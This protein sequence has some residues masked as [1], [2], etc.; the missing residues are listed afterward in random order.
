MET[1]TVT[2]NDFV[3]APPPPPPVDPTAPPR[4]GTGP[5]AT[6]AGPTEPVAPIP[7]A[8]ETD[9]GG[10]PFDPTR[11]IRTKHRKTGRWMPKRP[12]K[13][14]PATA[15]P[16][17]TT[18]F[19]DPGAPTGAI[20]DSGTETAEPTGPDP[21]AVTA[22]TGIGLIQTALVLLGEEEG[23]LSNA[24]KILIKAPLERILRKYDVGE[25]PAELDLAVAIAVVV[26]ARLKKPKTMARWERLKL[27]WQMKRADR[28]GH[29]QARAVSKHA[30]MPTAEDMAVANGR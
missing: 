14:G 2:A 6:T 13:N 16:I 21:V 23:V 3:T 12:A 30:P 17:P 19:I 4:N 15:G 22:E 25:L 18:S 28:R 10:V 27:W 24:E 29:A 7:E 9:A 20:D 8:A 26:I 1:D 5:T 11:H